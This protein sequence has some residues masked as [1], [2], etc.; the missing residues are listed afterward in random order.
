MSVQYQKENGPNR[1][2]KKRA[3]AESLPSGMQE[4]WLRFGPD[5]VYRGTTIDASLTGMSFLVEVSTNRIHEPFVQLV[6][7]DKKISMEQE[8]VYIKAIDKTHSRISLLL[9]EGNTPQLYRRIIGKAIN[10]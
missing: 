10:S 3:K 2:N 6:S 7:A 5:E 1:R 8:L 9:D 4:F